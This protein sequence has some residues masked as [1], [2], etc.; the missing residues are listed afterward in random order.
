MRI[1]AIP[2]DHDSWP[3]EVNG[4]IIYLLEVIRPLDKVEEMSNTL[5]PVLTRYTSGLVYVSKGVV[6]KFLRKNTYR[7]VGYY[8]RLLGVNED[9]LPTLEQARSMVGSRETLT[10]E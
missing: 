5:K 7:R 3:Q 4:K 1:V 2:D 8:E 10:I 9:D 6:L